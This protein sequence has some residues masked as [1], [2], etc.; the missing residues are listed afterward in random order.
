[1][2]K[3][4]ITILLIIA[5]LLTGLVAIANW[6]REPITKRYEY[7]GHR[8][9]NFRSMMTSSETFV[10]DPDCECKEEKP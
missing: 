3:F 10:H 7:E 5:L 4:T 8:Y 2:I 9:I 1:M 6:E